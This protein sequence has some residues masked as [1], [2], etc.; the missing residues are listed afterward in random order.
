M[1][2]S[3]RLW[4]IARGLGDSVADNLRPGSRPEQEARREA[5]REVEARRRAAPTTPTV[6]P[7]PSP[8]LSERIESLGTPPPRTRGGDSDLDALL[9]AEQAA[10][11]TPETSIPPTASASAT[12]PDA[13]LA[14]H[15]ATLGLTPG[16]NLEEVDR[17]YR[18]LKERHDPQRVPEG[19]A[20]RQAES[21]A[22]RL[23]AA[24]AALRRALTPERRL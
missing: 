7:P 13:P 15:Y 5:R 12:A 19:I 18:V 3:R 6:L 14:A 8:P 23:E 11:T 10:R 9:A 20:R 1:S 16:A 2:L 22:Q 24:Y 17:R 4:R 21:K